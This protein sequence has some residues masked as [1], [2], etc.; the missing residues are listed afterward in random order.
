MAELKLAEGD[1]PA[2]VDRL[3]PLQREA[4]AV[5]AALIGDDRIPP[6]HEDKSD[7]SSAGLCW[8]LEVDGDR[9]VGALGYRTDD[10]IVDLDR[11]IV[12]PSCHRRGIGS[13]LVKRALAEG[14]RVTVSTG[15]ENAPARRL[16]ESLGFV[17]QGDR[18]VIPGLWIS[19]YLHVSDD[20]AER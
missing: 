3:L 7:L 12:D 2:F 9:V 19:E 1:V 6:L 14:S 16:Y 13:R 4:Y 15:R 17:S 10:G 5:E 18:E 11:L 20:P 8:L